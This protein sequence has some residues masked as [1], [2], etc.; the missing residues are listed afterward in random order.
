MCQPA[1]DMRI[2]MKAVESMRSVTRDAPG[3]VR[4]GTE[5]AGCRVQRHLD[6]G[7]TRRHV[8]SSCAYVRHPDSSNDVAP[9]RR[10]R[11]RMQIFRAAAIRRGMATAG[12]PTPS[13]SM[14]LRSRRHSPHRGP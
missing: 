5:T 13:P 10:A 8:R 4:L 1:D 7:H 12:A 14:A 9:T 6:G 3:F 2:R 11:S